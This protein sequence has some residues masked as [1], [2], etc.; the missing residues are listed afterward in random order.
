MKLQAIVK[1]KWLG[2]I[3]GCVN[4]DSVEAK[5]KKNPYGT[6]CT[7]IAYRIPDSCDCV[8]QNCIPV[9]ARIG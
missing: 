1:L 2:E 7:A 3:Q 6:V 5:L 8:E 4:V 9:N